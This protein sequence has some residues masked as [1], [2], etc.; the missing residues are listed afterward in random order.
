MGTGLSFVFP[1]AGKKGRGF[2]RMC[3]TSQWAHGKLQK[4]QIPT[5]LDIDFVERGFPYIDFYI[6]EDMEQN[7]F[8]QEYRGCRHPYSDVFPTKRQMVY[9]GQFALNFPAKP[10]QLLQRYYGLNW[11]VPL[12]DDSIHGNAKVICHV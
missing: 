11:R 3:A 12:T 6:G 8:G 10:E 4:W 5:P 2:P 7:T 9:D 1:K